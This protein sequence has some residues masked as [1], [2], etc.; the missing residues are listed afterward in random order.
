MS[1]TTEALKIL[2]SFI[3]QELLMEKR[4]MRKIPNCTGEALANIVGTAIQAN[5]KYSAY[6]PKLAETLGEL[7]AIHAIL[8]GD[9]PICCRI[10]GCD[11]GQCK[12]EHPEFGGDIVL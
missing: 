6:T 2:A 5:L 1:K 12:C 8:T 10:C 4:N 7:D 9:D 11:L 3:D